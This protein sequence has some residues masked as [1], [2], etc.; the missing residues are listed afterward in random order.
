MRLRPSSSAFGILDA[1][2]PTWADVLLRPRR[3][4]NTPLRAGIAP[5]GP[6]ARSLLKSYK[7]WD[8]GRASW[9]SAFRRTLTPERLLV[10]SF[11]G[12]IL[13]GTLGFK[14]LPGLYTGPGL[15]WLD[16]LFTATSAVCVT[17]LIV[18]DTATY[19]TT[20]GQAYV[21]LLIQ[22]GGLGIV[23]FTTLAVLALGRRLSLHHEAVTASTANVAPEVDF[24]QLVRSVVR[25][26]LAL[27][28]VGALILF[29]AWLPRFGPVEAAGHAVFQAVSAFCNAGF[30]TFSDSLTGFRAAP[31]TLA[32]MMALIVLGGL[33]FLALEEVRLWWRRRREGR[34][35]RVSL[36]SRLVLVVTAF[37][38]A[39]GWIAYS[40]LEWNH[41]LAGMPW[42][43]RGL[44]ALVMSVTARTAGF[45]TVDYAQNSDGSNFVTILLMS[46]GGSPGSTAGGLKTTT[47]AAIGLLALA[48]LRG[49]RMT[50]VAGRSVPDDT[51][52]RAVGLF[53]VSFGVVTAGILL[54][55]V[56][57]LQP[58]IDGASMT[59]LHYMFEAVSAFNTVGLS[60]GATGSLEAEGKLL[61]IL[62]M[63]VGRVG[64]L[65]LAAA[66]SLRRLHTGRFRYAYE[67]VIIG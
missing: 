22:L 65:T 45:N 33:G 4:R 66:I 49:R 51:I 1:D 5:S 42:W 67:D 14:V 36:H 28:A 24:R 35:M 38:V 12:L 44:N 21:L 18:V 6:A 30:S 50:S 27:E 29:M 11:A 54:F 59:F 58:R 7:P 57:H 2:S 64:P 23:T 41:Q 47:V 61:T 63:Y 62:L 34:R 16:A 60:M 20:L 40:L 19:F 8:V 48:R 31:V 9:T 39:G 37:L 32:T 25:F 15:S 52:H 53:V 13:V 56:T 46:I 43:H 17:G 10:L 3:S 26:T 55:A